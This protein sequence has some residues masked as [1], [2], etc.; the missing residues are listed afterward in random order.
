MLTDI[1]RRVCEYCGG[2]YRPRYP[3][4]RWCR[5]W[6]R[7]QAKAAEGRAARRTWFEAGR[8]MGQEPVVE[9]P[10]RHEVQKRKVA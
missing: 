10:E 2:R 6:C 4:Q 1:T 8:P 3:T 7:K 5:H 9:E